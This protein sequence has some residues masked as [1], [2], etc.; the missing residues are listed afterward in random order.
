MTFFSFFFFLLVSSA[1]PIMTGSNL[2]EVCIIFFIRTG[3]EYAS[4][5][6]RYIMTGCN[7]CAPSA[8]RQGQVFKPQR[9]PRPPPRPLESRVPPPPPPPGE[10]ASGRHRR[11]GPVSFI[12]G[13]EVSGPNIFSIACPKIKWFCPNIT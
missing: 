12:G 13:A 1:H 8:L 5:F 4:F 3:Y 11:T 7:F 9:H 6:V 2:F 10:Q